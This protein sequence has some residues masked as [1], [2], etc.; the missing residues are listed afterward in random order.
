MVDT[1]SW[2]RRAQVVLR[3]SPLGPPNPLPPLRPVRDLHEGVEAPDA[4][5]E[6]RAGLALGHVTSLLPYLTQD[7]YGRDLVE[8]AHDAVVVENERVRATFL[9]GL[10]GRLWSL[11]DLTTGRELL[12]S[13]STLQLGNLALRDAWFAGGVEWN[14][15]TTGH[16]PL[17]CAPLHASLVD[18]DDGTPVLRLHE[19]ERL[20][21]LVQQVDAWAPPGSPALL[22]HVRVTNPHDH[23][24]PVYWWSNTAVPQTGSTR[25][26]V[27]ATTA[28]QFDY[29]RQLRRVDVTDDLR[30]P[31]SSTH[32]ADWF[33]DLAG[34]ERPWIAAVDGDGGGLLQTSTSRL[35]G[36]KLFVWGTGQGGRRWQE[37]L[38]PDGEEYLEIQ[39]GLARTQLE[40]LL[41]PARTSWSWLETFGPVT[42]AELESGVEHLLRGFEDQVAAITAA[43]ERV[44]HEVLHVGSGWGAV[45]QARRARHDL[46]ALPA[47]TPFDPAVA[48]DEQ[49]SWLDLLAGHAPD[50]DPSVPPASCQVGEEWEALLRGHQGW[51]PAYLL[52]VSLAARGRLDDARSAWK[53]SVVQTDNAWARRALAV[54]DDDQQS[55]GRSWDRAIELAPWCVPLQVERLAWVATTSPPVTV[56]AAV[57]AAPDEVRAHPA[58]RLLE[59]RAA[60]DVGDLA[61]STRLLDEEGLVV[62]NLREGADDLTELWWDHRA[63]ALATAAG[64]PVSAA[65]RAGARA[66]PVPARYDFRMHAP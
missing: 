61:R 24:V 4:D 20:R 21:G 55:A 33:F 38:S 52:G 28:W 22:V 9:P 7:G 36:R 54:T 23:D 3:T 17:T 5:A 50:A 47:G 51:L 44:P 27:P 48:G 66:E 6:M 34:T 39:A 65:H 59:A 53:R 64:Q 46:P 45:E 56:L 31:T 49:R 60:V 14:L 32:A 12:H 16:T 11:V 42:E 62:P 40:H 63:L 35:R 1:L 18:L 2:V 29:S 8:T 43:A 30:H 41:L 10:G 37:W 13:P 57:D 58:V 26:H 15:G 25:V 19:Y